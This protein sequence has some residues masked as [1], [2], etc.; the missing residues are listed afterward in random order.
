MRDLLE[1][2]K[3]RPPRKWMHQRSTIAAEATASA[4][5]AYVNG[6]AFIDGK[7][8]IFF[9]SSPTTA[10]SA[11]SSCQDETKEGVMRRKSY[12]K[13]ERTPSP[14][15]RRHASCTVVAR[16]SR[17]FSRAERKIEAT[18]YLFPFL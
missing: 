9:P 10:C 1:D 8:A 7:P 5:D 14:E 2:S 3:A 4:C 11:L 12:E 16:G 17:A 6:A 18:S 13:T 15:W